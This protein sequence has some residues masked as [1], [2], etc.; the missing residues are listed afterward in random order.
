MNNKVKVVALDPRMNPNIPG[1]MDIKGET[2]ISSAQ[3]KMI[4][5][6]PSGS[7]TTMT[8]IT[9]VNKGVPFRGGC[10]TD[11]ETSMIP[12]GGYSMIQN[13]RCGHPDFEKRPG[14]RRLHTVADGTNR[15]ES[16]FQLSKGKQTERHFFAQMSD[17]DVLDATTAP[18]G[19]TTGVFG[20][21]V[22]SA[23]GTIIPASWAVLRDWLLFADGTDVAR[24]YSGNNEYVGSFIV[25]KGAE[26]IPSIPSKGADYSLEVSTDDTTLYAVLDSLSVLTDYDCIFIKTY[27][28]ADTL[29]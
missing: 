5:Q 17:G 4:S 16:M 10:F 22:Y 21:E 8:Q 18:P 13:M 2:K 7:P 9:D 27:T 20:T 23:T 12:L 25:Y 24:I 28:P 19:V 6:I 11:R 26:T 14:C 29:T 3:Q 15:V 1:A